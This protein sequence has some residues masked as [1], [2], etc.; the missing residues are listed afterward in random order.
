MSSGP[1]PCLLYTSVSDI[2]VGEDAVISVKLASDATGEV[3]ITV[4]G[5]DYTAAIENGVARVTVSDLKAGDYT[6]AIKYVGD[7]KYTGVEVAENVNVAKAQPVLGVVIAD[8]DY[9]N[10]FVIE[11][12]VYK[13]QFLMHAVKIRSLD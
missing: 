13:R 9:G 5:E 1:Y 10:G 12:D 7:D 4:N 3:V 2:K 6:V 8:V 11:A